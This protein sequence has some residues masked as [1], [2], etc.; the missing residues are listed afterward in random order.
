MTIAHCSAAFLFIASSAAVV[1]P[2]QSQTGQPAYVGRW[3]YDPAYCH[4]KP[5]SG[6]ELPMVVTRK[7]I[8]S[9]QGSCSFRRITGGNGFWRAQIACNDVGGMGDNRNLEIRVQGQ[10]LTLTYRDGLR[11]V[12]EF[13][14][15]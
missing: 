14:R 13:K 12:D 11:G 6:D 2:A 4:N 15:C 5:G 7:G 9:T 3:S 8:Q 10:T 1:L